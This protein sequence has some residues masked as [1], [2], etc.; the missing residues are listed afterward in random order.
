MLLVTLAW[1]LADFAAPVFRSAAIYHFFS[2]F[3][4][5]L[6]S[7]SWHIDGEPLGL[8]VRCTSIS[9]GLLA[10]LLVSRKPSPQAFRLAVAITLAEWLFAAAIFDS[11]V[12]RS[13]TG[14]F[15]GMTAAP[16]VAVGVEEMFARVRTAHEM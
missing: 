4:H 16:I 10:G 13:V 6:P 11:A 14:V 12:L 1:C 2:T 3:C 7:R 8:C 9:L 5:Q 15:L